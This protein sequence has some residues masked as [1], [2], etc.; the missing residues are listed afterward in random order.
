M[1]DGMGKRLG[2]GLEAD[3]EPVPGI[4]DRDHEAQVRDLLLGK[5]GA[6]ATVDLVGNAV[7]RQ[8]GED[9]GTCG[10]SF[11]GLQSQAARHVFP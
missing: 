9:L 8:S 7:L 6:D 10:R 1:Q 11:P 2:L 3:V 4:D 5:L